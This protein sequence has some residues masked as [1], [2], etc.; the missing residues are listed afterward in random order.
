MKKKMRTNEKIIFILSIAIL[1]VIAFICFVIF[2]NQPFQRLKRNLAL[3]DKYLDALEY[4]EAVLAYR[5]ALEIDP[6]SKAAYIGLADAYIGL[7]DYDMAHEIIEQGI[8]VI[9]TKG[10]LL[11]KMEIIEEQ[12]SIRDGR[13]Q[14]VEEMDAEQTEDTD[15]SAEDTIDSERDDSKLEDDEEAIIVAEEVEDEEYEVPPVVSSLIEKG[16]QYYIGNDELW[17]VYSNGK[18]E[19]KG[20]YYTLSDVTLSFYD[21]ANTDP[22]A[23]FPQTTKG[24]APAV[25]RIRKDA[26]VW[27]E[28]PSQSVTAEEYYTKNSTFAPEEYKS[29]GGTSV[30][31]S[32]G[33]LFKIDK[34]GYIV[35]FTAYSFG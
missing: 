32:A 34:D 24:Y 7:D 1:L 15:V 12:L 28:Y 4:D 23:D 29:W 19:D 31:D 21:H 27:T 10:A 17:T 13:D 2:Y 26:K 14:S 3:G 33:E 6:K 20:D 25:F 16:G 8:E 30:L 5:L 11:K 9:G 35:E 18:I 22:D